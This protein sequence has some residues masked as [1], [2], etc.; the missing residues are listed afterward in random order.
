MP[1]LTW[2]EHNKHGVVSV[3]FKISLLANRLIEMLKSPRMMAKD[4]TGRINE[5]QCLRVHPC[6]AGSGP[7]Q[8]ERREALELGGP[9]FDSGST[10]CSRHLGNKNEQN[11]QAPCLVETTS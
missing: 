10:L 9:G 6:V 3:H 2:C 11:Q 1:K 5:R 8:V 4:G 7:S